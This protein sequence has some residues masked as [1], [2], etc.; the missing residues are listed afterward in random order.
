[1]LCLA[2]TRPRAT[3]TKH[4]TPC[5]QRK[6]FLH[7]NDANSSYDSGQR[8]VQLRN[9]ICST[10]G[11]KQRNQLK[12]QTSSLA[13]MQPELVNQLQRLTCLLKGHRLTQTTA[14]IWCTNVLPSGVHNIHVLKGIICKTPLLSS[15]DAQSLQSHTDWHGAT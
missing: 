7:S 11:W 12:L 2:Q 10:V 1:M 14:V 13:N 15:F 3:I 9:C 5:S 8:L 6:F 4:H